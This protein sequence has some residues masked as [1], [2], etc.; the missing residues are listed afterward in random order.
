LPIAYFKADSEMGWL[1]FISV[2]VINVYYLQEQSSSP[3]Y[4][5]LFNIEKLNIKW[6]FLY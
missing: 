2:I 4:Y 5:N 1:F 3:K 6:R